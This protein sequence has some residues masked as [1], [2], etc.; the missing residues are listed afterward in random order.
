MKTKTTQS[1]EISEEDA[2][3]AINEWLQKRSPGPKW[4]V[5]LEAKERLEGG[6]GV[7]EYPVGY[8]VVSAT[9]ELP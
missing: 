4:N 9:R 3:E 6:P 1:V 2:R 7:N 8:V 5:S